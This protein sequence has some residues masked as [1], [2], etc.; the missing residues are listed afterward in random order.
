MTDIPKEA[1]NYI[2][3]DRPVFEWVM[4]RQYVKTDKKVTLLIMSIAMLLRPLVTLL[5]HWNCFKG[6]ITVSLEIMKIVKNLPKLEIR[7]TE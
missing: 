3:N 7:E 6:F 5:I 1:Y 2:V 4:E